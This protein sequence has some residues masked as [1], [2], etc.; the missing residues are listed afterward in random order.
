MAAVIQTNTATS[1][2]VW[3]PGWTVVSAATGINLA[4]GVLY[5]WSLF[6]GSIT[7]SIQAGGP[8]AFAWNLASVNDPYAIC[9]LMFA[10]AMIIAGKCQD[11]FGP[12]VTATIGGLLVGAGFILISQT[13]SYA[14][15]VLG[16]GVMVGLGLGFGYSSATPPSLKWFPPAKTGLI[17]GVVVSGFGLAPVYIAPLATYL[18]SVYGLQTTMLIFGASFTVVV[19]VLASFLV[20][21]PAG[22]LFAAAANKAQKE[23]KAAPASRVQGD[24]TPGQML[25]T[26]NFYILW[27]LY[28]VGAGA[29]LMVIGSIA[30]LAKMSLGELAFFAVVLLAVGNAAGRIVAGVLSDK[31][32]RTRTLFIMLGFQAILMF[33][34]I[35]VTTAPQQSALLLVLLAT[36]I[37]FNYGT[38]L[39]LFPALTKDFWGMKN[40]GINY[41]LLFTAWGIGGLVLVRA[42]EM[43]NAYT[44]NFALSFAVAGT[45]LTVAAG[46]TLTLKDLKAHQQEQALEKERAA[47]SVVTTSVPVVGK[48]S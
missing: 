12:R 21:P 37:G 17:A 24:Y 5:A 14:L 25:K 3:H 9:C 18:L 32:G 46:V 6:K 30:G 7:A 28:L 13:T 39:A 36:F 22:H 1:S 19:C 8:G 43:M 35:P 15:W 27:S 23:L 16:F 20:N 29:G 10:V 48:A 34:A 33:A 41:G 45:L 38:N 44:G 11:R 2:R 47:A 40:F 4:L 26:A 42:A 31:I